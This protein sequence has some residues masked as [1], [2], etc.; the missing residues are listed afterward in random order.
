M[1][2]KRYRVGFDIGGTFTDFALHDAISGSL[3]IHKALTTAD[4]PARGAIEGIQ[5]LLERAR[6]GL[7]DVAGIVHGTTLVTNALI[8]GKGAV[9]A[10]LTTSGFRDILE[11]GHEQR[12]DVYDLF[13]KYPTP[14]VPRKFRREIDERITS[15]GEVLSPLE[16][17]QV[18]REVED[19]LRAGVESI[20]VCF[21]HSYRNPAH[22]LMVGQLLRD[23][24]PELSVSLS[25]EVAPEVRE[26][27]RAC[28]TAANAFV[29]PL[30]ARYLRS[31]EDGLAASGFRGTLS[32]MLS[33]GGLA[34][35]ETARSF[36]IRL[37]ESGPAGGA[38][39][40]TLIGKNLDRSD[41]ISFDMG[42][43]TAKAALIQNGEPTVAS[44]MEVARVHRFKRGSGFPVRTPVVEMIEIGAGGGSIAR[45]DEVG[46]IKVGP[47]SAGS[48]PG[49]ACYGLGG[50]A[51]TV[52]DANLVLGYLDP[53]FFLGGRMKLDRSAAQRALAELGAPLG[54]DAAGAAWGVY[55]IVSENMAAAAR[56][57]VIER[58][59]DPRSFS[60][61]AFGGA[62]PAH[63]AHVARIIGVKEVVIPPASGA[64]SAVGFLT[65]PPAFETVRS[66]VMTVGADIDV[67]A[68]NAMFS[69][70]EETAWKTLDLEGGPKSVSRSADMRLRGQIHEIAVPLPN[71]SLDQRSHETIRA[72]FVRV[73]ESLYRA[74]PPDAEIEALSWR[75]RVAAVAPDIAL[76]AP[77]AAAA[78]GAAIKGTRQ[79]YFGSGFI[80]VPVYDRYA[81]KPGDMFD[82]PAIIEERESTT[83]V[84]AGDRAE[85][86]EHLNLRLTIGAVRQ[87]DAS[88]ARALSIPEA[89]TRL[90]SDPIGLE[91]MW[92]RLVNI[93]D[94]CWDAV[95]RTAFSLIISDAQ[96]FSLAIFDAE[97]GILVQSPRAQPVFNLCLPRAIEA[98]LER[99]PPDELSP[100]DILVTN[101]P[102]LTS[103]H[104]FDVAIVTPVFFDGRVVGHIGAI[105]HVTDIGGTRDPEIAREIYEE[106]FQIPPMRLYRQGEPNED[107][108]ALLK[109]NVR[110]QQQ[111]LG[112]IHALVGA[113][114]IGARRLREFLLEYGMRDLRALKTIFQSRSEAAMREAIRAVPN[115]EYRSEIEGLIG[116]L[117]QRMPVRIVVDD[118]HISVDYNGAPAQSERGGFNCTLNYASAHALYPFKC[119]LTPAVRSNAGCLRPF[120]VSIPEGTILNARKPASVSRRQSTGW[121]LGPATFSALADA[122]P[123]SVKAFT[124]L[125]FSVPFF[126]TTREG[127]PFIDYFFGGGG[128]GGSATGDGKSGLL[129]PIGSANT[130]TELFEIR[131]QLLVA[132]KQL[133][134]DSGGPGQ[135]RGGLGQ[136]VRIMKLIDDGR[137]TQCAI[138]QYGKHIRVRSM[139]GGK[140]GGSVRLTPIGVKA[141]GNES[142]RI[143]KLWTL[144][145]SGTGIEVGIAGGHGY[146]DPLDRN[147]DL[148]ERDLA[149]GYISRAR[150]EADYGCAF[151]PGGRL[152]RTATAERRA[153]LKRAR[154]A[155]PAQLLSE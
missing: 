36:P 98:L 21:L 105:G 96:D 23:E 65:A 52:T 121:Y 55:T 41:L 51:P 5:T 84:P 35:P 14:L 9:T 120:T 38:L 123:A 131:T 133:D 93:T 109:E 64:A 134:C 115:G 118:D 111:V 104:L 47:Q 3:Q 152:D 13:L 140:P 151:T 137:P 16:A 32:L 126:G 72:N 8:E 155:E 99:F 60:V 37:L 122:T 15:A 132:E 44:M 136:V 82:G 68:L 4:D 12:Y 101:D 130:S 135:H 149:D 147:L 148:I 74:V 81:L 40:T 127:E 11:L 30:M 75:V 100:G 26:Y 86:D 119:L 62:G 7:A 141:D 70:I 128:E 25:C 106:G 79:A 102:W 24:F 31:L 146:G 154:D 124:G 20:S 112:D 46:L 76:R 107:L 92:A 63:A 88:D 66:A 95:C 150:A 28:T 58:G 61:A 117:V 29:Q 10:L 22:E 19:L 78:A 139:R 113:S 153:S 114:S 143:G 17:D 110:D 94:E 49:P 87:A 43:T 138:S 56:S 42:G 77:L 116:D 125:P 54:L 48:D 69:E 2:S 27:A 145:S 18:R 83:V 67:A 33:S 53:D 144:H 71:G 103:G 39:A 57:H 91:I 34:T 59:R 97:G 89:V 108:F 80:E 6:L 50:S 73:Y 90:E 142:Q 129:Y 1:N 85:V 45:L